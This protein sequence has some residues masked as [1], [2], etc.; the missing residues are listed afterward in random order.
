[1]GKERLDLIVWPETAYPFSFTMI[2]RGVDDLGLQPQVKR[3]APNFTAA[4]WRKRAQTIASQLHDWADQIGSPMLVGTITYDH[5]PGGHSKYNSAVLF[6]PG[7][8][9]VQTFHKMHLVPFGEYVPLVK[10]LP[11]LTAL[12]PYKG[13]EVPSL[14][15]GPG[16]TWFDVGPF[17]Y[18]SAICFE[19]TVPHLVRRFFSEAPGGRDPDVLLNLSNDGWFAGSSEHE[20]HLAVSVFRAIENRVP[21]ARSA[22]TG[23][24][25]IIDGNGR[26]LD[27]LPTLKEGFVTGIVPLDDRRGYY[28]SWGDWVGQSCLAVVIGLVVLGRF[29][30]RPPAGRLAN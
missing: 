1:V 30:S 16:P 17:R 18:A 21:L 27:S 20:M 11:F 5:R 22:N 13:D 25:A 14:T 12:T 8:T 4:E 2:D 3:I 24:S 6:A 23:I 29:W 28:P 19:D 9:A 10:T 7:S 26:V 15:F